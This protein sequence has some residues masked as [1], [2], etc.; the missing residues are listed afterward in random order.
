VAFVFVGMVNLM[1]F[2][3]RQIELTTESRDTP[4]LA[5]VDPW[6]AQDPGINQAGLPIFSQDWWL[7]IARGSSQYRELKVLEGDV[8][9]G[10]FPFVLSRN[11]IGLV[12]GH[13]P[14]WS[15][16]GGPI[17]DENLSRTNQARVIQLLLEQLPRSASFNFV[18]NPD[19]SYADLVR[20]AF[21]ESGF[22]HTTQVTYLRLPSRE[23][24]LNTRKSKH[25]GHFRRAARELDCVEIGAREFVR[26]FETNLNAR[27]KTSY[28]PL[29]TLTRLIEEAISRKQARAIAA[30]PSSLNLSGS[31]GGSLSY[32]AAIVYVWD[33]HR[34]YYWLSTARI[35]S[36]D[37][38]KTRPHPDATKLLAL[39]A[40]EDAQSMSL[41]FDTD[42]VTTPGS[43][44][45]YRNMFGLRDEQYR[46]IFQRSTMLERLHQKCRRKFKSNLQN[47]TVS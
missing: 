44:N 18:C 1:A 41:T 36:A 42:G 27:G 23:D 10:R 19:L 17:V 24:V 6:P 38:S 20:N 29:E 34:C 4:C 5:G 43:E 22:H 35:P 26:F 30:M 45:L 2:P 13:D 15:H 37:N 39:K 11:R 21:K 40:M 25:R 3:F 9:I 46:D 47:P 32:D 33:S 7:K 31:A 14:H 28:S 12:R 8:T 16:L